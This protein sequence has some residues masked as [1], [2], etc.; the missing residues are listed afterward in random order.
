M[1][2][3]KA[4]TVPELHTPILAP[5]TLRLA[6]PVGTGLVIAA[7]SAGIIWF[8]ARTHR[9]GSSGIPAQLSDLGPGPVTLVDPS[10]HTAVAAAVAGLRLPE[11]QRAQI[12]SAV[13]RRERRIGWIVL[14]DSMDPDGDT[15]AVEAGGF[16]QN[17]VLDNGWVPV[18][19]PLDGRMPIRITGVRDG[20]G[21]GITVA[22]ATHAG[23]IALRILS[24]GESVEVVA[25]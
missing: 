11:V 8:V 21:G 14:T 15:V 1:P 18:A 23:S 12:E 6:R 3:P 9:G 25:P 19:V 10:D 22:V 7:L 16:V 5:L 24:P 4:S 2:E 20:G 17:V 13:L